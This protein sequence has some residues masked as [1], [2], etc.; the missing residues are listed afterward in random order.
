MNSGTN[1]TALSARRLY[2]HAGHRHADAGQG[3]GIADPEREVD[4]HSPVR[5]ASTIAGPVCISFPA[6]E[7]LNVGP[8][9]RGDRE[10]APGGRHA[11]TVDGKHGIRSPLEAMYKAWSGLNPASGPAKIMDSLQILELEKGGALSDFHLL[12]TR[13]LSCLVAPQMTI[14]PL[15]SQTGR[16]GINGDTRHRL[17]VTGVWTRNATSTPNK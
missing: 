7:E 6:P 9:R 15:G 5:I 8:L 14:K 17:A 11:V 2:S 4:K 12:R 1:D 13:R 3:A 10:S 16:R